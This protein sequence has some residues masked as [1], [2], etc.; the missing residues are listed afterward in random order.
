MAQLVSSHHTPDDGPRMAGFQPRSG[1]GE[2]TDPELAELSVPDGRRLLEI[3]LPLPPRS[4]ELRL[5]W[6]HWRRKHDNKLAA[7]IAGDVVF[8]GPN[9]AFIVSTFHN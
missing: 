3:A 8:F 7:A 6:F 2:K 1:G 9:L 5:A 4:R